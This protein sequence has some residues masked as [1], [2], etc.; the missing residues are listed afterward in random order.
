LVY[1]LVL[2]FDADDGIVVVEVSWEYCDGSGAGSSGASSEARR[3]GE[4][5]VS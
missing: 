1:T 3:S 4:R 5:G 2:Q